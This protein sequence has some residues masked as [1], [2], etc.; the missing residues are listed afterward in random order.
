MLVEVLSKSVL[1]LVFWLLLVP[2]HGIL[3]EK[4]DVCVKKR[5]FL[6]HALGAVQTDLSFA[7]DDMD[8]YL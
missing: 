7:G 4:E 2:F 8:A 6:L 3:E 1:D 5:N